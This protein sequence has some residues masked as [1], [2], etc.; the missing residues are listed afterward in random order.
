MTHTLYTKFAGLVNT[1]K[2]KGYTITTAESCTG[3]QIAAYVTNV[4]G[5]SS[6]LKGSFVTYS[7]ETKNAYVGVR[8]ESVVKCGVV[9][10]TVAA[11]MAVGALKVGKANVGVG[12]TGNIGNTRNENRGSLDDVWVGIAVRESETS[13]ILLGT[14]NLD[15]HDL[16]YDDKEYVSR[17]I[18]AKD[19]L[20][21]FVADK[22]QELLQL[23]HPASQVP[24]GDNF[25]VVTAQY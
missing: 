25:T 14:F 7:A 18:A 19:Y 8:L 11:Q 21:E 3:G 24:S 23:E 9:S 10:Q 5:A 20:C 12:I 2:S 15:L 13:D 22:A 17:R 1:L 6:V 4:D 16:C